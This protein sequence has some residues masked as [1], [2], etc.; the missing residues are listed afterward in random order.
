VA[1]SLCM[2][3]VEAQTPYRGAAS[4]FVCSRLGGERPQQRLVRPTKLVMENEMKR[5]PESS[6]NEQW[7]FLSGLNLSWPDGREYRRGKCFFLVNSF[8][9]SRQS[10]IASHDI[11]EVF[12]GLA[13]FSAA[14]CQ[15]NG[16]RERNCRI[17]ELSYI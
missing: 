3:C 8:T 1:S 12:F 7:D 6:R 17:G 15:L 5:G 16:G 13:G 11:T 4:N 14:I 10:L 2:Q 9:F